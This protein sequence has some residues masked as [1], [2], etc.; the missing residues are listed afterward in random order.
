MNIIIWLYIYCYG[1][2]PLLDAQTVHSIKD[3]YSTLGHSGEMGGVIEYG[4]YVFSGAQ[5]SRMII[6]NRTSGAYIDEIG[7]PGWIKTFI[8]YN[9]QYLYA[10]GAF[11]QIIQFDLATRQQVRVVAISGVVFDALIYG[12]YIIAALGSGRVVRLLLPSLSSPQELQVHPSPVK[13]LQLVGNQLYTGGEEGA[14]FQIN[15]DSWS[16]ARQL[17][18]HCPSNQWIYSITHCNGKLLVLCSSPASVQTYSLNGSYQ[19]SVTPPYDT[20]QITCMGTNLL[21]W[22]FSGM[23]LWTSETGTQQSQLLSMRVYQLSLS[24][25]TILFSANDN[26]VHRWKADTL[27]PEWEST[28]NLLLDNVAVNSTHI[29]AGGRQLMMFNRLDGTSRAMIVTSKLIERMTTKINSL[30][31]TSNKIIAASADGA[32]K[33]WDMN[34]GIIADNIPPVFFRDAVE[35]TVTDQSIITGH[36]QGGLAIWTLDGSILN[37][38]N[39]CPGYSQIHGLEANGATVYVLC[40][41]S[42]HSVDTLSLATNNLASTSYLLVTFVFTQNT[43]IYGGDINTLVQIDAVSGRLIKEF[44][45]GSPAQALVVGGSYII[46]SLQFSTEVMQFHVSTG[47]FITYLDLGHRS[48][49]I[50]MVINGRVL[51]SASA[52]EVK[53]ATIPGIDLPADT[54]SSRT[55]ISSRTSRATIR[56]TINPESEGAD[57]NASN[58]SAQAIQFLPIFYVCLVGTAMA[59]PAAAMTFYIRK[60]P[61]F[62]KHAHPRHR[63]RTM[64]R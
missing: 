26:K 17:P 10:T 43:I 49:V 50:D 63:Q 8:D 55:R 37:T 7:K 21:L 45:T 53:E 38:I 22:G 20:I 46:A 48:T 24:N 11:N 9:D 28:T 34:G 6:W 44:V 47:N 60:H 14:V 51:V 42:I 23:Y 16:I 41:G 54:S 39:V 29:F 32:L 61:L 4:D 13:T 5:D 19:G 40:S 31:V 3:Y 30:L 62:K 64:S 1:F 52:Y 33:I 36:V 27:T 57:G 12:N 35:V 58:S 18:R 25:Q 56:S 59:V 15:L 2:M